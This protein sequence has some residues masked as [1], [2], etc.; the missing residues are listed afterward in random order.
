MHTVLQNYF[1]CQKLTPNCILYGELGR[2]PITIQIKSRMV[3]FWQRIV[4]EKQDKI[5]HRLYKILLTMHEGDFFRSKWL[6]S[7]KNGLILSGNQHARDLQA[8]VPLGLAKLVEMKLI[9]NFKQER[10]DTVSHSSKCI[11]NRIFK[12]ELEFEQYFNLLP[13]DLATAVCHFRSLNHKLPIEYGRLWGVER[14]DRTCELCFL[15][16]LGDEFHYLF[17]CSYFKD[18]RRKYLPR[19]L[20]RHPNTFKFRTLMN[21]IKSYLR[22]LSWASF[23]MKF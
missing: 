13:N 6:L 1:E 23:A 15:N 19:D 2:Y 12:T 7:V 14:D 9:E 5:A 21:T 3:G 8:N 22:C 16:K 20:S 4:N 17:E 10:G 18:Q 11:N